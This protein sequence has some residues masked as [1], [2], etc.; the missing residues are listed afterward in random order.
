MYSQAW[1]PT[2]PRPPWHRSCAH[3]TAPPR[4]RKEHLATRGA[5]ADDVARNDVLFG[6][7]W[8]LTRRPNDDPATAEALADIVVG[9]ALEPQRDACRNERAE[10]VACRPGEVDDDRV[11]LEDPPPVGLGDLVAQQGADRAVDVADRCVDRDRTAVLQGTL[12]ELDQ[13]LVERKLEAVVLFFP[14]V[15]PGL[16][17]DLGQVENR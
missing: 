4:R 7:E 12:S 6:D 14:L 3:R 10:A 9:V 5:V 16:A 11:V 17:G 2:P 15:T 8:S 1:S 13:C